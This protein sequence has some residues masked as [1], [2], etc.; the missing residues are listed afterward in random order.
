MVAEEAGLEASL[1]EVHANLAAVLNRLND[2]MNGGER[3]RVGWCVRGVCAGDACVGRGRRLGDG[4][5]T[6]SNAV[7]CN[8]HTAVLLMKRGNA[9]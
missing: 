2:T 5:T 8:S 9:C 3:S 6:S 7:Q 4:L 1:E